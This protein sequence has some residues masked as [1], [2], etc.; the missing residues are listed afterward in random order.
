MSV[1]FDELGQRV[2]EASGVVLVFGEADSGKTTLCH[3]LLDA[4]RDAGRTV[5]YID[6]DL[7]SSTVGPPA[8]AGLVVLGPER[9]PD[10][11]EHPTAL[12]FVGST[13]PSGV[14]L[15]H[16]VA[17]ATLV[18]KALEQTDLV[19]VDTSSVVSGV[20][21]QTLKYHLAELT[22]PTLA[23]GIQRGH[24]LDP[25]ISMLRRFFSIRIAEAVTPP[26]LALQSPVERTDRRAA[27]F[28]KDL[29]DDP[30]RWRVQTTVFAPTLPDGF[31][32]SRLDSMLVGVQDDH[33]ACLGLGVLEH[34]DG[35]IKVA[36]QY[37]DA[38]RGLRLGSIRL[39]LGSYA[40][41]RVRLR[42]LIFGV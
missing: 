36:T 38:M 42:E 13:D 41:T 14:V 12:R 39:D 10:E 31:D 1:G 34:S 3:H 18:H 5:A 8:C 20:V 17:V 27:A 32:V 19:I 40:T 22:N 37:G 30:A 24:E 25:V 35:V 7:G 4:A 9:Q 6:A 2:S 33:G 28:R 21:G 26:D 16:S 23:I 15:P 11:F 29:G